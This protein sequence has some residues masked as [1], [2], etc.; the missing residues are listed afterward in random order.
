MKDKVKKLMLIGYFRY[1]DIEKKLNKL[2]EKGLVLESA[3]GIFW[4]F[5]KEKVTNIKYTITFFSDTSVF[6]S[7]PNNKQKDYYNYAKSAGW[8]IVSD[9]DF[10]Q[11]FKSNKENP[12]P[13]H[14][15]EQ[16]K[17]NNIKHCMSKKVL[18]FFIPLFMLSIFMLFYRISFYKDNPL[19]LF[20]NI[21]TLSTILSR[22]LTIT[23]E[24]IILSRYFLWIYKSQKSINNGGECL[25]P[26][27]TISKI[28][29]TILIFAILIC[30]SV[31]LLNDMQNMSYM[32]MIILYIIVLSTVFI[33]SF[34]FFIKRNKP[35]HIVIIMSLTFTILSYLSLTY[36][37]T[38]VYS[39]INFTSNKN[40]KTIQ[41]E[42]SPGV[43]SNYTMY[44]DEIPLKTQDLYGDVDYDYYSYKKNVSSSIFASNEE[45]LQN[46]MQQ[47]NAPKGL[48][49]QIITTKYKFVYDKIFDYLYNLK[50]YMNNNVK[51]IDSTRFK[52]NNAYEFYFDKNTPQRKYLL[53]YDEKIVSIL[54]QEEL[55]DKQIS[56]M[57]KKLNL[58]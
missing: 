12:T 14:T 4:T 50:G 47:E 40:Y 19:Y 41:Y 5:K 55:S 2:S 17:L 49:Y 7:S 25:K 33:Y 20:T 1:D 58:S 11:I 56:I 38:S 18:T 32:F 6:D 3:K 26:K 34:K 10:I 53:C 54:V 42:M 31:S 8:D 52:A 37:T 36:I 30:I 46:V 57:L 15:D 16:V 9:L 13:F 21:S 45:Y 22:M 28:I 44:N 51:T 43:Y 29:N 24:T 23:F 48:Q 27:Y 35:E 39:S